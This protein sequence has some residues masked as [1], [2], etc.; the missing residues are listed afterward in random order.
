[1]SMEQRITTLEDIAQIVL[2]EL[3][4]ADEAMQRYRAAAILRDEAMLQFADSVDALQVSNQQLRE[5][6]ERSESAVRRMRATMEQLQEASREEAEAIERHG[7]AIQALM[8]MVPVTQ[9]EIVRLDSRIDS[10]LDQ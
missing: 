4:R 5:S 8:S 6:M 9:A 1:M 3:R 7:R 2:A 10:L